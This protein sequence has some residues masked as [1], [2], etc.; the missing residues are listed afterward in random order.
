GVQWHKGYGEL[1]AQDVVDHYLRIKDPETG[2]SFA[3]TYNNLLSIE[4][5]GRYTVVMHLEEPDAAFLD[6]IVA[7]RAGH[8]ANVRAV[9][10][11]GDEY[12][13]NPVGTGPYVFTEWVPGQYI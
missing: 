8:I 6:S 10:E 12:E 1:T 7:F 3:N 2:S 13:R 11:L 9:E 4:A 5:L